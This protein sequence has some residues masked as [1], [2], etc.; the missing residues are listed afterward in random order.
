MTV[1]D[2]LDGHVALD[3][4]CLDRIYL[5]AYVPNLQVDG[6][7]VLPERASSVA[8]RNCLHGLVVR[9]NESCRLLRLWFC[10]KVIV[11]GL[12]R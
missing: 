2:V 8:C 6:Q 12:R 5:N 11:L 3:L 7:I 10:V 4:E 9:D 1:N